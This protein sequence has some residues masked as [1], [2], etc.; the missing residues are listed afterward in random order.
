MDGEAKTGKPGGGRA[1]SQKEQKYQ[2]VKETGVNGTIRIPPEKIDASQLVFRDEHAARHG[3]K[4]KE[5]REYVDTAYCSI[6]RSRWDGVSIN[7]YSASGAAYVDKNS[8]E[9]KTSFSREKYDPDTE[10]LVEVF[11]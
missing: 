2:Q 9:I 8:M 10:L 6:E 11:E 7:Y 4:V 1:F 5:A 3:C